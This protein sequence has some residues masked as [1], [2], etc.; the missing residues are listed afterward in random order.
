M[1]YGGRRNLFDSIDFV[2]FGYLQGFP[3]TPA[4]FL[5]GKSIYMARKYLSKHT[6]LVASVVA[7]V[8]SC[9][10]FSRE[11]AET[12]RSHE[13]AAEIGLLGGRVE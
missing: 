10:A 1:R 4:M 3:F 7:F 6:I 12:L 5:M 8:V 11:C 2:D 9:L 13:V